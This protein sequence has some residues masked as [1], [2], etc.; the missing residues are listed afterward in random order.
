MPDI[1]MCANMSC[2]KNQMCYRFRAVP[3]KHMQSYINPKLEPGRECPMFWEIED[4]DRIVS[5]AEVSDFMIVWYNAITDEI[6]LLGLL[7]SLHLIIDK[8]WWDENPHIILL[9]EL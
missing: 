4:G 5:E 7:H 3:S 6:I 9:G 8:E 1:S 2:P